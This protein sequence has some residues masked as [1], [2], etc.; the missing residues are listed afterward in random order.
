LSGL[1]LKKLPWNSV[2]CV[3]VMP[4]GVS[5]SRIAVVAEH[6]QVIGSTQATVGAWRGFKSTRM[7]AADA[8]P[9]MSAAAKAV[10][11]QTL[12][13]TIFTPC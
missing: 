10:A 13:A 5:S 9:A 4:A 6:R 8:E 12:I 3:K 1:P 7:V 11:K 2:P